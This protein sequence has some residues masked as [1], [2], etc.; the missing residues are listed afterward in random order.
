M[1]DRYSFDQ[2][3][4]VARQHAFTTPEAMWW[5][6]QDIE[7]AMTEIAWAIDDFNNQFGCYIGTNADEHNATVVKESDFFEVVE[8]SNHADSVSYSG[9]ANVQQIAEAF[10]AVMGEHDM[11]GLLDRIMDA[12]D[13]S[14]DVPMGEPD[15]YI[16]DVMKLQGEY[17]SIWDSAIQSAA[18]AANELFQDAALMYERIEDAAELLSCFEWTESGEYIGAY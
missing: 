15:Y 11:Q 5:M 4:P 12:E 3:S 2:L 13:K 10:N 7:E 8:L 9:A 14:H 17:A 6:Q 16:Y 18:D 1:K